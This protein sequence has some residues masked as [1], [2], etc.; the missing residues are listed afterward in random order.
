[1]RKAIYHVKLICLFNI[2]RNDPDDRNMTASC[3]MC[4][5]SELKEEIIGNTIEIDEDSQE[6]KEFEKKYSDCYQRDEEMN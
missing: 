6:V 5:F 2:C 3:L 1:M 4:D